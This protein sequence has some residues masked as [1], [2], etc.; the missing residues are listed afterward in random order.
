[1]PTCVEKEPM[2]VFST[3]LGYIAF[4]LRGDALAAVAFGHRS[5]AAA[6]RA[7]RL[8]LPSCF[9]EGDLD[10]WP[11]GDQ[12]VQAALAD[13]LTRLAQGEPVGFDDFRVDR[14]GLTRFQQQ[15]CQACRAIPWGE[16]RTYGELAQAVGRPGAARAVGRVMATNRAPLVVPCHRVLPAGGGLGGFSAPQGV[17]MKRRLLALEQA[18]VVG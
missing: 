3:E 17:A 15:V 9:A 10:D 18:A 14:S 2:D 12:A 6:R 4:A 5:A 1:M 8:N 13:R 11:A 7:V 16:T